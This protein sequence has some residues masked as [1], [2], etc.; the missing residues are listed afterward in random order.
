M[1]TEESPRGQRIGM[2]AVVAML[3]AFLG[4]FGV[5]AVFLLVETVG[6]SSTESGRVLERSDESYERT[7][8]RDRRAG[9]YV[10]R[11]RTVTVPNGVV[12]GELANGDTWV[13]IGQDAY[14]EAPTVGSELEVGISSITGRVTSFDGPRSFDD[15]WS[16]AGSLESIVV[17]GFGLVLIAA[18]VVIV[19]VWRRR[20]QP[21]PLS[22]RSLVLASTGGFVV[23]LAG[24]AWLFFIAPGQYDPLTSE[25]RYGGGDLLADP[26]T[27]AG[28]E[29]DAE[30]AG[31]IIEFGFGAIT[32]FDARIATPDEW[33]PGMDG[34]AAELTPVLVIADGL[35]RAPIDLIVRG[36]GES[37]EP[38]D[39]VPCGADLPDY[40]IAISA[41]DTV[42]AG[43]FCLDRPPADGAVLIGDNSLRPDGMPARL[44]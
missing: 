34:I 18:I 29:R 21:F 35:T 12:A 43:V 19:V 16:R 15:G 11:C 4:L 41:D 17:I 27:F 38:F 7:V 1:D 36:V 5:G 23:G 40:P 31:L 39:P 32:P 3:S 24:M 33:G 14:D 2:V 20:D 9:F 42:T 10:G 22:T 8:C 13:V 28:T 6:P 26:F 25:E 37:G 44:P 30:E